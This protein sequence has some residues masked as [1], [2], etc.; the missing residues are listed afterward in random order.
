M[1]K[2]FSQIMDLALKMLKG[3]NQQYIPLTLLMT[4]ALAIG[5]CTVISKDINTDISLEDN[6]LQISET[7][8]IDAIDQLGPPSK[9][10]KYNNGMV[11]LYESIKINERQLGFNTNYDFWRWFKFSIAKG[12]ADREVLLLIFDADGYLL[13]QTYNN[14]N[15][16]LGSGQAISFLYTIE[17]LVDSSKLE[18]DPESLAW[19]ASLLKPLPEA[20]NYSQNLGTGNSG[21]EQLGAPDSV[22][23]HSLELSK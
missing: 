11:F 15:E 12:S 13:A 23:Q 14:F 6:A 8:F 5:S 7:H 20:L 16:K 22:G 9:L 4:I 1:I 17:S 2:G 18:E 3:N 21:V 10:S 19:G